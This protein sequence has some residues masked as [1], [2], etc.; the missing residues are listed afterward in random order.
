MSVCCC[1]SFLFSLLSPR[2]FSF[3]SRHDATAQISNSSE[4]CELNINPQWHSV[5]IFN[6]PLLFFSFFFFFFFF[7]TIILWKSF[8]DNCCIFPLSPLLL[9]LF[10]SPFSG[11]VHS[12]PVFDTM[13]FWYLL[14][15]T[16]SCV[17]QRPSLS[18]LTILINFLVSCLLV[19]YSLLSGPWLLWKWFFLSGRAFKSTVLS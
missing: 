1:F 15:A 6:L 2:P 3:L 5:H 12:L 7:L 19:V 9:F 14:L 11:A 4:F 18:L 13:L 17:L 10:S 8:V 16:T